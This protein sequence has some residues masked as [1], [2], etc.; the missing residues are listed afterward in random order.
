[1]TPDPRTPALM[2]DGACAT[3][4]FDRPDRRNAINL[5][6][7]RA[8]PLLIGDAV[9]RRETRVIVIRGA[10]GNFAAGA[11]I[12][13]FDI[14]F[15]DRTATL[16]YLDDM[17]AATAAIEAAPVPVIAQ[18]NGLCI[19]AGVAIA[20]ACDL[21]IAA[22]DARFAITPAKLGLAYSAADTR[23]VIRAIGASATRD[24][25][26]TGRT[27]AAAEALALSLVDAVHAPGD[28][29]DAI[30]AKV[31]MIAA[32][33]AWTHARSKAI[34]QRVLAGQIDDDEVTRGW[35]ADAPETADY[36]EGLAAFRARRTPVFPPR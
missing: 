19:G 28:I 8:L 21:R 14:V 15:A 18:I 23:R 4:I 22:D 29:D 26:F 11:D 7:W 13:E 16:A 34:V 3:L 25:L 10:G 12:A 33:S 30:A 17:S 9:A 1:M 24:L 27:I 36:L 2:F 5:A 6:S 31:A 35:F 32:T 20:A